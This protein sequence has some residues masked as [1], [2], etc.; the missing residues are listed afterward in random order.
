MEYCTRKSMLYKTKVEYGDY[1][2]NHVEGCSH[3]C[4]YPCYAFMMAKRFGRVKTYEEWITPKLASNAMEIL[5]RELPIYKNKI[6]SVHFSFTTDPFMM[7]YPE[8][9]EVT[10]KMV[11]MINKES[12]PCSVLTKG[13]LPRELSELG[14]FNE[15]G[16]SLIS[17]NED[18][19]NIYEP[20]TA[21]Y[22]DRIERLKEMH[23]KGLKTWVS[24]EPY[25]TP[26]ILEQSFSE[27]LDSIDFVNKIVFGRLNHNSKVTSFSGYKEFYNNLSDLVIQFC[28]ERNI[29]YH[30]KEGTIN[31]E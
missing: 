27:I 24:I 23:E 4:H 21:R 8:I 26:N 14:N 2:I 9:S 29:E 20:N 25:P 13:L 10:L 15:V 1:T 7:G 30:I 19:R 28:Q 11:E 31:R 12:I 16:I 5:Q 3:G 22:I 18:F 6:K 17:L